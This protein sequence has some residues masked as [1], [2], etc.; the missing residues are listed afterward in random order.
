MVIHQIA[1]YV[2]KESHINGSKGSKIKETD[3]TPVHRT[4]NGYSQ[5]NT[6]KYFIVHNDL[7]L[8]W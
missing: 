4:N 1:F 3:K 7:L 8:D 6:I 2:K 5:A